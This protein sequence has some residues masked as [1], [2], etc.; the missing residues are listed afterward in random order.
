M[1]GF[2]GAA[3]AAGASALVLVTVFSSTMA[4]PPHGWDCISCKGNS[5][6]AGNW[7]INNPNFNDTDLWWAHTIAD[8]YAAYAANYNQ[9]E[10]NIT[11]GH[12]RIMKQINP[13]FKFLVYQN[14]ELGP[15]TKEADARIAANPEWWARTDAGVPIKTSQG[16]S[17]NHSVPAVRDFYNHYPLEVFGA[18]A[19]ELLDGMFNDGMGYNPQRFAGVSLE[20]HDA[21]FEG[22]MKMA[23]EARALYGGLN[24]GEVWGNGAVGDT[25]IY[26][27]FTYKGKPVSWRT[28]LDHLDTGFLEGAGGYWYENRTTGEW[29]PDEFQDFLQSVIN[30]STGGKTIVLHFSPGPSFPPIVRYPVHPDPPYN[31]FLALD[32]PGHWPDTDPGTNNFSSADA[33]RK[34]AA[35]LLVQTLAPF[36]IVAN[37]HVFLQYAWF[38]EMQDGNIPCPAGIEC[39]MPSEWYPEFSK[40][41]GAPEGPA[42]QNGPI[43]TREF[44]HASVYV[45]VRARAASKVTWH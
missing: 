37:E 22:K 16:Y 29:I 3:A 28:S 45:D 24:G 5:M 40:P 14:S 1:A 2:T 21:W 4:L 42:V 6:L 33:V 18:D 32:W 17:L 8:S 19:K 35:D 12:A 15:M 23:D 41:I 7:A 20:R 11:V 26:N 27:N 31:S 36:L 38:Y 9:G 25:A 30:A 10:P 43:W 34:A 13:K 39:G 44:A